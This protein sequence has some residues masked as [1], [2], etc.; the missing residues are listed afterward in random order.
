MSKERK[1]MAR[2]VNKVILV[3]NI[4]QDPEVRTTQSGNSVCNLSLATTEG[5][6]VG[7][8]WEDRTEWH[9]VV[10]FG[11]TAETGQRY[12]K[13]GSQVYIEGRVQTRKWQDKDGNDRWSTEIVA[14]QMLMLG[15]RADSGDGG[16]GG[17]GGVPAGNVPEAMGGDFG[18]D[19]DLPF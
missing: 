5:V 19:D 3:G 7:D 2:G 18:G 16:G 9:R 1:A 12:L 17:G 13:K 14:R 15:G 11:R 4:G 8:A 6:K 10:L